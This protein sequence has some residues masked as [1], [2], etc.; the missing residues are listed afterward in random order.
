MSS[1][2]RERK[3]LDVLCYVEKEDT[4]TN[5]TKPVIKFEKNVKQVPRVE[6]IER[7]EYDLLVYVHRRK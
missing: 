7:C 4:D 6:A 1:E 3:G 2:F 5:K